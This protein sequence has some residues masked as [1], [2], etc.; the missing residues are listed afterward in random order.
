MFKSKTTWMGLA[1]IIGSIGY[2]LVTHDTSG[3]QGGI[4]AGLV[5]I[6]ARDQNA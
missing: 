5:G 4:A 2:A 1:S 6:L 3:L